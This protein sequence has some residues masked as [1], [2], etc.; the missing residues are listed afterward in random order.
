MMQR[1]GELDRRQTL[2]AA[3]R[4]MSAQSLPARVFISFDYDR[5]RFE[6][7]ALGQQLRESPRF[8]IENWSMKEAAPERLWRDEAERRLNRS[9]VMV[10]LVDAVTWRAR[11]V[12]AEVEIASRLHV[13][14]RMVYPQAV[15]R[16]TRVPAPEA[17]LSLWSHDNL[18]Q[19]LSVPRRT[20][21]SSR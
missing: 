7:R 6:A 3:L 2:A 8:A 21:A 12:L 1:M 13:P 16:P 14:I 4:A 9:D 11:G 20:G 18:E 5:M 19:I 10:I 15:T 17:P